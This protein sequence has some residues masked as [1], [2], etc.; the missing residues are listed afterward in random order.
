[1]T[2]LSKT[3]RSDNIKISSSR[4]ADGSSGRKMKPVEGIKILGVTATVAST[5]LGPGLTILNKTSII[6]K[7]DMVTTIGKLTHKNELHG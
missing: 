6:I 2:L 4:L 1:M 3:S 5:N 7:N